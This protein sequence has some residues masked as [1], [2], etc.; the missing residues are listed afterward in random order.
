MLASGSGTI[1]HA[2][3][4]ADLPIAVLV[5]DRRCGA[6]DIAEAAGLPVELIERTAGRS[7]VKWTTALG[8]IRELRE[9]RAMQKRTKHSTGLR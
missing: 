8:V 9:F 7:T 3:L 1:L 5:V 6:I 2:M 4:D